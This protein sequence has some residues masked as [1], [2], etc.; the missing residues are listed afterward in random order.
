MDDVVKM[1]EGV[2]TRAMIIVGL[3]VAVLLLLG[4]IAT[5][6]VSRYLRPRALS[7]QQVLL[8]RRAVNLLIVIVVLMSAL[9]ELGFGLEPLLGAAGVL[10]VAIGFASQTS[11]SNLISGVFLLV[12][13]PF[14]VGDSVRVGDVIGEVTNVG[15]MSVTLRTFDNLKVRIPNETVLKSNLVN[16]T[17]YEVRR[18]DFEFGVAYKED[19]SRVEAVLL[20]VAERCPYVL[21]EPQPQVHFLK[22]GTSQVDLRLTAWFVTETFV[23]TRNAIV[24]GV[25]ARLDAERIEIPFPHLSLYPGSAAGAF[26]VRDEDAPAA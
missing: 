23:E 11:M 9:R 6:V 1:W 14:V 26:T 21:V 18:F 2:E 4:M 5:R 22:Y 24:A 3:K 10:S 8:L 15:W 20:D 12:E 25:K 13:R 16:L 7:P 17:A 19:L